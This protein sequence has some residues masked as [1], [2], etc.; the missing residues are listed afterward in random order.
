MMASP[1]R[2]TPPGPGLFVTFEGMEGA[3]KST[4]CRLL[5]EA[6][7]RR[8]HEVVATREPGGTPLGEE[9]RRILKFFA[10][11]GGV[12]PPAELLLMASCRAQLLAQVIRPALARG[13]V[14]LCDRFADSTTV[15]QGAARGLDAGFIEALHRFTVDDCWPAF[16]FLLDL[17]VPAG[18]ARAAGRGAADRFENEAAEFHERVRAGFHRLAAAHPGR[19]RLL[20]ATQPAEALHAQILAEVCHALG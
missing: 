18:L 2:G 17:P 3:G 20:A 5:A 7:R 16:T 11:D 15:Y 1:E 13:A 19:I 8:G 10:G 14:V 12:C 4:Q 6:L 9:L